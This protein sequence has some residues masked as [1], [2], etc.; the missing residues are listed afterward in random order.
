[1]ASSR[2]RLSLHTRKDAVKRSATALLELRERYFAH[3]R[4]RNHSERT[5]DHYRDSFKDLFRFLESEGLPLTL[6]SLTSATC[7]RYAAWLRATPTRPWRGKTER[8]IYGLAGRMRDLRAFVGWLAEEELLDARVRVPLPTLPE[9]DFAVF[10]DAELVA[11]FRTPHLT[12]PGE[13]GVR[14]RALVGIL[15]DTGI[16]L[17][18]L[19]GLRVEDAELGDRLLR[20]TGK[21]RKTRRVP[22]SE[23]SAGQLRAWLQ[24]RGE[25]EGN[26]F[27][28]SYH[29]TR[30]LLKRI[31][32][33][34]GV[35]IWAHRFRHQAATML[36]RKRVS[37][38]AIRRIM[39]HAHIATTEIYV[40]LTHQDLREQH[41]EASPLETLT[42]MLPERH[43]RKAPRRRLPPVS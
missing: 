35:P 38:S 27:L 41:D 6:A 12:A 42:A 3:H 11:I 1:V 29:G 26:L 17:G 14:N 28:L 10:S 2:R 9:P 25:E 32:R 18:E 5:I 40:N 21:G 16:R 34:A 36:A 20:V 24:V 15:L 31:E 8:S 7:E 39:G 37:P 30:M 19:A 4:A 22:F 43:P 33:E 13:Q 23:T